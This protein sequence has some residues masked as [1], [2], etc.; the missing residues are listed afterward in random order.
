M[1]VLSRRLGEEVVIAGIIRVTIVAAK[2]DRVR[3]GIAAPPSV[4]VH[5]KEVQDRRAE[6]ARR[7]AR[8]E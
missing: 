4:T 6:R 3:I 1:L 5:R 7:K 8:S 2:G